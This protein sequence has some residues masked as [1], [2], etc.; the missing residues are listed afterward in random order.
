[1]ATEA[2]RSWELAE[3]R[4]FDYLAQQLGAFKDIT[5]YIGEMPAKIDDATRYQQ[6]AFE[7]NGP[8]PVDRISI[9][10]TSKPACTFCMG[11]M[12]TAVIE[13]DDDTAQARIDCQQ[14]AGKVL[15]ALPVDSGELTG[16]VRLEYTEMPTIT[17]DMF[18]IKPDQAKGG[19]V[20]VWILRIPMMV[21]FGNQDS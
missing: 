19:E 3:K 7:I 21:V 6:W 9:H 11:A 10:Q 2:R 20:R 15:D 14:L 8:G 5:A 16:I 1:M 13:D 18:L 4:C 17:R 12:F